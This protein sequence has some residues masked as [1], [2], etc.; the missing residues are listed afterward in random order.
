MLGALC[1][2]SSNAQTVLKSA[3][4]R[5]VQLPTDVELKASYCVAVLK[6]FNSFDDDQLQ[7]WE[8]ALKTETRE[9]IKAQLIELITELK[10]QKSEDGDNLNRLQSFIT[11][12]LAYLESS[13]LTAAYHRGEV[14]L[15][16]QSKSGVVGQCKEKCKDQ[17]ESSNLSC[18]KSCMEEDPPTHRIW[19]CRHLDFLPY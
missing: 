8:G 15:A 12:K 6:N 2:L 5:T 7:L 16:T 13:A 3:S 19:Q 17:S 10:L 18:F 4:G 9:A 14:D 11:P 1:S